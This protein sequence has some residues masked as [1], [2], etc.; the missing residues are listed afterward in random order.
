MVGNRLILSKRIIFIGFLMLPPSVPPFSASR[1]GLFRHL[2]GGARH[3]GFTDVFSTKKDKS[4]IQSNALKEL[5]EIEPGKRALLPLFD[6][7]CSAYTEL[8]KGAITEVF[9]N[10]TD[11]VKKAVRQHLM[12]SC[13][14]AETETSRNEYVTILNSIKDDEPQK[15]T[16]LMFT[17]EKK[18]RDGKSEKT[19]LETTFRSLNPIYNLTSAG[20]VRIAKYYNDKYFSNDPLGRKILVTDTDL[21]FKNKLEELILNESCKMVGLLFKERSLPNSHAT[22]IIFERKNGEIHLFISD[23][24]NY[25]LN[26]L[27]K[28]KAILLAFPE[29]TV[30]IHISHSNQEE[31]SR[32][33]DVGSCHSDALYYLQRALRLGSLC[34]NVKLTPASAPDAGHDVFFELPDLLLTAQTSAALKANSVE[35]ASPLMVGKQKTFGDKTLSHHTKVAYEAL[36]DSKNIQSF[37]ERGFLAS[38]NRKH[39]AILKRQT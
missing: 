25:G 6:D 28:I 1:A 35:M 11:E 31:I 20:E 15:Q 38:V 9:S 18:I 29:I 13:E 5:A 34:D 23:S 2:Y 39:A 37:Q 10:G 21:D 12:E 19:K 7:A 3:L 26:V 24:V 14:N 16:P 33:A 27:K 22:P 8:V 36:D 4:A 30:K 32:Q 17:E